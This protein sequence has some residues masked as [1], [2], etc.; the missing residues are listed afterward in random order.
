V[1]TYTS[2]ATSSSELTG[3]VL[4]IASGGMGLINRKILA[5]NLGLMGFMNRKIIIYNLSLDKLHV[6]TVAEAAGGLW[7]HG[8]WR[9]GFPGH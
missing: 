2:P 6:G 9:D 3:G 5:Y 7:V 1:L 8:L 4:L